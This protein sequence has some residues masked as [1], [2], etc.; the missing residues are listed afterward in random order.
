MIFFY[1]L[2]AFVNDILITQ[3]DKGII[4]PFLSF[5]TIVEYCLFSLAIFLNLKKSSFRKLILFVSPAFLIFT[6]VQYLTSGAKNDIDNISI[7]VEYILLII[8]CLFFF[9]EE[10]N[11]PNTTFIYSSYRFW[12]ITGILLYSTG[13][14][15]L[16]MQSSNL[17]DSQWDRW[18]II[19]Y[20]FTTI[21]NLLFCVAIA[22]KTSPPPDNGFRPPYD[23]L[24]DK[25]LTPL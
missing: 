7:T 15:F 4:F 20:V 9:F 5:F 17:S 11:E 23:E 22:I 18:L 12:I 1:C 16:F 24:F 14:F 8:Y 13:T 21:K 19:N 25:P 3:L 2:Y 10:L 6:I